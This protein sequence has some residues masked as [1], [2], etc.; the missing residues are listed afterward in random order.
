MKDVRKV[1][2]KSLRPANSVFGPLSAAPTP[3]ERVPGLRTYSSS[4]V[5]ATWENEPAV[6]V[7]TT[8]SA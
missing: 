6:S 2:K 8:Y 4:Y 3:L 5:T 7:A 1:E